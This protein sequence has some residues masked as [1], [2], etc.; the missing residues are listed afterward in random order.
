VG[1]RSP[2]VPPVDGGVD[3]EGKAG[4]GTLTLDPDAVEPQPVRAR[5]ARKRTASGRD[6]IALRGT[7]RPQV[8]QRHHQRE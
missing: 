4:G 3:V 7:G 6:L 1:R 2:S 5:T 8:Q